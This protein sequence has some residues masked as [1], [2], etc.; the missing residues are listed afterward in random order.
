MAKQSGLGDQFYIGGF[1]LSGDVSSLDQISGGPALLDVTPINKS[2]NV[3]IAGL[4]D[5]DLQFTTFFENAIAGQGTEH[6]ALK[7]L[8]RTDTIATYFRGAAL[9]SPAACING[10][11]INYDPTRDN[12]GNLTMKVEVQSNAF[13]LEW[14]QQ[15]T[16]GLRTD[17]TATT[18]AAFDGLAGTAFGAQAYLQLVSFTGTSVD[19]TI[20]HATTSGGT[21]TTLLDFGAQ[22][23]VGSVRVATANTTTVNEFLKVVTAGTFTNAVFAVTFVRNP[24]AG[25]VF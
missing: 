7:L 22:T 21:Y 6:N 4:R 5:G 3:R 19:V 2:A 15:L 17:T 10:K 14:G 8:P 23:A 25:V 24:I 13:G 9:G 20:T 11:Q 16:A 18:G 1:D 12:S